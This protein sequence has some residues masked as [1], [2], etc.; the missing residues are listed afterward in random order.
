ML[1]DMFC[2]HFDLAAAPGL[3]WSSSVTLPRWRLIKS[4]DVVLAASPEGVAKVLYHCSFAGYMFTCCTFYEKD[5]RPNVF[6]GSENACFINSLHIRGP[7]ITRQDGHL[8]TVVPQDFA[9]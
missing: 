6:K 1:A 9:M 3:Q 7:C 4:G 8:I 5:K 2:K